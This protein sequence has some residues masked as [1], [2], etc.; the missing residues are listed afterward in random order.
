MPEDRRIRL[1]TGGRPVVRDTGLRVVDV[2]DMRA[3]VRSE[4]ELLVRAPM[5]EAEDIAECRR[6]VEEHPPQARMRN[7][8][9]VRLLISATGGGAVAYLQYTAGGPNL[10]WAAVYFLLTFVALWGTTSIASGR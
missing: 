8:Q 9:G 7:S 5:L 4:E 10:A 1:D 2:L 6:W 3:A